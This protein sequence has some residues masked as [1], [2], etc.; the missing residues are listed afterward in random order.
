MTNSSDDF[1]QI[2]DSLIQQGGNQ[3]GWHQQLNAPFQDDFPLFSHWDFDAEV[4]KPTMPVGVMST[5][6]EDF[7]RRVTAGGVSYLLHLRSIDYALKR[8]SAAPP[9]KVRSP[10][11]LDIMIDKTVDAM[12]QHMISCYRSFRN[13]ENDP[14]GLFIADA[15]LIRLQATVRA[16]K[17][18]A[19]RGYYFETL[20]LTRFAVEQ[21]AWTW[22]CHNKTETEALKTKANKCINMLKVIYPTCGKLYGFLSEIIIT[23]LLHLKVSKQ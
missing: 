1:A 11:R 4:C 10:N 22:T 14:V 3:T 5:Y 20:A 23:S 15:N 7:V 12:L 16:A 8:Y 19:N 9:T 21:I 13:R 6:P 18:L 17:T 2:L